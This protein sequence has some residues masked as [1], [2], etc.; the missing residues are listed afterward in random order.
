MALEDDIMDAI[1]QALKASKQVTS[2]VGTVQNAA[3]VQVLA[4]GTSVGIPCLTFVGVTLVVGNRVVVN[5]YG[6]QFVVMG[7]LAT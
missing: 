1:E 7:V 5:K 3:P 4:D 2:F 6:T